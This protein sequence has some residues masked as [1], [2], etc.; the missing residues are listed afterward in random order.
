MYSL[1]IASLCGIAIFWQDF[2]TREIHVFPLIGLAL[3]GLFQ[4][5]IHVPTFTLI[6]FLI[7][8]SIIAFILL[9][10]LLIY[11]LR[12]ERKIMDRLLGWGDILSLAALAAWMEP[13]RFMFFYCLSTLIIGLVFSVLKWIGRV[14]STYPI[15]LAGWL[16]FFFSLH[17][18]FEFFFS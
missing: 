12:G 17:L 16:C 10:V 11:R 4:H 14:D 5:G 8:L 3:S 18:I 7:N 9:S 15:P 13:P 6:S 2:K 1:I